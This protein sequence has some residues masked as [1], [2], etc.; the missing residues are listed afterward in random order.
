LKYNVNTRNY[1][2]GGTIGSLVKFITWGC[3]SS[4]LFFVIYKAG[5][6]PTPYL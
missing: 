3:E 4:A 2:I 1:R 5:L 6:E